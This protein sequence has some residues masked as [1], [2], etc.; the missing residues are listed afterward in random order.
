MKA[1]RDPVTGYPAVE[2]VNNLVILKCGTAPDSLEE[3]G[4]DQI[5]TVLTPSDRGRI[6]KA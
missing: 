5:E 1:T 6:A 4:P 3:I 2:I